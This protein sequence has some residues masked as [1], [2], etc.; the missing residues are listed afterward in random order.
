MD[1]FNGECEQAGAIPWRVTKRGGVETL[2]ITTSAG[3]WLIP[4]GTIEPGHSARQTAM[5]E[6]MEEAGVVGEATRR[7][8]GVIEDVRRDGSRRIAVYGL[9]VDRVLSSWDEQ[10]RRERAWMPCDD[11]ALI[12]GIQELGAMMM[13]LARAIRAESR[14]AA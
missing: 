7:A 8:L 3:R 10:R 1:G 6:A 14:D 9:R 5:R 12:V 11:A 2:L 13:E 4:K